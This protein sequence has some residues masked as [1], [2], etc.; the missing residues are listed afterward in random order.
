MWHG[1]PVHNQLHA[2]QILR[3]ERGYDSIHPPMKSSFV[4]PGRLL[5]RLGEGGNVI[6]IRIALTS[7]DRTWKGRAVWDTLEDAR[8]IRPSELSCPVR[9]R[10]DP[11]DP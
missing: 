2:R 6:K 11:A 8:L 9:S 4:V 10:G 5:S 3:I 1:G 7:S